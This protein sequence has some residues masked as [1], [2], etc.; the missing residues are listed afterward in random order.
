[1]WKRTFLALSMLPLVASPSSAVD[2]FPF[3]ETVTL[4]YDSNGANAY[5]TYFAGAEVIE[6]LPVRVRHFQGGADDGL[7]QFWSENAG[8]DKFLHGFRTSGG[9]LEIH[10]APPVLWID[11]PLSVGQSWDSLVSPV[12]HP[13]FMLHF[14]VESLGPTTV[15]AGTVES[16]GLEISSVVLSGGMAGGVGVTGRRAGDAGAKQGDRYWYSDG[17][18]LV[19]SEYGAVTDRL[20]AIETSTAVHRLAWGRIR[21]LYR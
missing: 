7:L 8:G 20:I 2:V 17:T 9:G 3:D 18:G 5:A 13:A 1:M 15:P 19:L 12:G 16:Y 21:A 6:G 14:S 10:Y 11:A 4:L